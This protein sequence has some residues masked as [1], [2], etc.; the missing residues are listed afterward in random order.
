MKLELKMER[1]GVDS[2]TITQFQGRR[3]FVS[4]HEALMELLDELDHRVDLVF[5]WKEGR[6][7]VVCSVSLPESTSWDDADAFWR[8]AMVSECSRG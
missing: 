1:V 7:E 6:S 8:W 2:K 3:L 5:V 4:S